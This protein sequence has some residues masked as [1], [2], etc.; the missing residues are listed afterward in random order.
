[1]AMA[2][3]ASFETLRIPILSGREFD[4]RDTPASAPVAILNQRLAEA[5]WPGRDPIGRSLVIWDGKP[6][7]TVVGLTKTVK[8][9]PVG[10]PFFMI[11]LPL[12][13]HDLT[14]VTLSVRTAPG[15][16]DALQRRL[17]EELRR[18]QLGLASVRVRSLSDA[19]GSLLAIP[20]AV[21]AALGSLGAVVL[22]LAVVGLYGVTA[23]VAGRRARECAIRRVVGASRLSILRLLVGSSMRTVLVGLGAGVGLSL[24]VGW[25]LKDVLLGASFDPRALVWAPLALAATALLAV[26]LPVFRA[27]SVDPMTV[28]RDE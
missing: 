3:P 28:L 20:R 11:Y 21:V 24:A 12:A 26:A 27:A 7:V 14:Q 2:G 22:L 25:L 5:L 9:F 6:A 15:Q 16:G 18:L 8:T 4:L 19:V 13:Q 23:Y 1:M 17:P 10:P